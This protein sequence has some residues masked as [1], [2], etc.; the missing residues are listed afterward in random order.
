M[1]SGVIFDGMIEGLPVIRVG[2]SHS[3]NFDP[4]DFMENNSYNFKAQTIEQLNELICKLRVMND[5]ERLGILN[6]GR[7][8]VKESFAPVNENTLQS[9]ISTN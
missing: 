9:F 1:A 4:A 3:L 7:Q 6:Y 2:R 5:E 8:F